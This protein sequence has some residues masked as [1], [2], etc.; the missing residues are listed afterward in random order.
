MNNFLQLILYDAKNS[1][2]T[3]DIFIPISSDFMF[4]HAFKIPISFRFNTN[5][6]PALNSTHVP[7]PCGSYIWNSV[8]ASVIAKYSC[9]RC[10]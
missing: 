9:I 1:I 4:S 2:F 5:K 8:F 10:L 3:K 6:L 7:F